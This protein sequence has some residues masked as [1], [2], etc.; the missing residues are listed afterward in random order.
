MDAQLT[1][2]SIIDKNKANNL[3][4]VNQNNIIAQF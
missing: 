2:S 3:Q 4:D 1:I